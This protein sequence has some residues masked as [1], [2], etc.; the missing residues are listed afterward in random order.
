MRQGHRRFMTRVRCGHVIAES[1]SLELSPA[2]LCEA[3]KRIH[4]KTSY[5]AQRV[6]KPR[7][8]EFRRGSIVHRID[9]GLRATQDACFHIRS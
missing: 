5:R 2:I 9:A 8:R 6:T 7:N 1:T 4:K 3:P